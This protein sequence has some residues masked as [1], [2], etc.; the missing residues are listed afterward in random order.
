LLIGASSFAACEAILLA[1]GI[2]RIVGLNP[3]S[4]M[5]PAIA[6]AV[7]RGRIVPPVWKR[8]GQLVAT[9]NAVQK[10]PGLRKQPG[11]R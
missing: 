8:P 7:K 11:M 1:L 4:Y 6:M 3:L 2:Y 9:R 5:M 10:R